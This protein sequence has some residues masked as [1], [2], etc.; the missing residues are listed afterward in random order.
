[1][2]EHASQLV[3]WRALLVWTS[4]YAFVNALRRIGG[5]SEED[6]RAAGDGAAGAG[7]DA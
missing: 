1:M 7:K 5:D 4:R 3:W 6:A 2:R